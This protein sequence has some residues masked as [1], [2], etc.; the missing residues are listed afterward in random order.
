MSKNYKL[1]FFQV[2]ELYSD[3]KTKKKWICHQ[4]VK[5]SPVQR[6]KK[7][8]SIHTHTPAKSTSSSRRI[9]PVVRVSPGPAPSTFSR[10]P[11]C[12]KHEP[13]KSFTESDPECYNVPAQLHQRN[14]WL[15]SPTRREDEDETPCCNSSPFHDKRHVPAKRSECSNSNSRGMK[16]VKTSSEGM[17]IESNR[18]NSLRKSSDAFQGETRYEVLPYLMSISFPLLPH[19]RVPHRY[20]GRENLS[21]LPVDFEG[22]T[23]HDMARVCTFV[24]LFVPA[25]ERTAAPSSLEGQKIANYTLCL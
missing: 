4:D 25:S 17:V 11:A 13:M 15:Q 16:T 14:G 18:K 5:L 7:D 1:L 20:A 23:V 19:S 10:A 24:R 8:L 6:R 21:S 22:Q 3:T 12:R 2:K 9:M